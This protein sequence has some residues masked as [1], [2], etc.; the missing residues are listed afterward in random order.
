MGILPSQK[1]FLLR[2]FGFIA[3]FFKIMRKFAENLIFV[4]ILSQKSS[5]IPTYGKSMVLFFHVRNGLF[6][7]KFLWTTNL[8]WTIIWRF[9][10]HAC[11]FHK[12]EK[13]VIMVGFIACYI[14][15]IWSGKSGKVRNFGKIAKMSGKDWKNWQNLTWSGKG[16]EKSWVNLHLK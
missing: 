15:S 14:Q 9:V 3:I 16:Q 8:N 13:L 1:D 7:Q 4:L 5:T 11:W 10:K 12:K 6:Y 2:N